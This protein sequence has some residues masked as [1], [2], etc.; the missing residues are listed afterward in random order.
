[1][2]SSRTIKQFLE[3][4]NNHDI[5]LEMNLVTVVWSREMTLKGDHIF[6]LRRGSETL[7]I[8]QGGVE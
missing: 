4:W 7:K 3:R 6:Q 1:M 2:D 5:F 8:L